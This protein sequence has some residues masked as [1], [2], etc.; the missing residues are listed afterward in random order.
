MSSHHQIS[1][2]LKSLT[3]KALRPVFSMAGV[4]TACDCGRILRRHGKRWCE[5]TR[6]EER[7]G[8]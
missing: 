7:G 5:L 8:E 6:T 1:G 2:V 3:A 4:C